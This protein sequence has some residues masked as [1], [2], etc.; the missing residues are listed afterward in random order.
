MCLITRFYGI[1]ICCFGTD[2]HWPKLQL[3]QVCLQSTDHTCVK[4]SNRVNRVQAWSKSWQISGCNCL[5]A[6]VA[7]RGTTR[8]NNMLV[9]VR[10]FNYTCV[11]YL[12][13]QVNAIT[14]YCSQLLHHLW[15]NIFTLKMQLGNVLGH[16]SEAQGSILW[17][18]LVLQ[19][20]RQL[21]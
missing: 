2:L 10:K 8:L 17:V 18:I 21:A 19:G 14:V 3:L 5:L 1:W 13:K 20:I 9:I 15:Q 11:V 6:F 7:H 12:A 4:L 16:G